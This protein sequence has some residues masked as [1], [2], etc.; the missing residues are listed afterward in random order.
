MK[1]QKN[2]FQLAHDI[3]HER[4]RAR[5][6]KMTNKSFKGFSVFIH[7]EDGSFFM[8]EDALLWEALIEVG[9]K[10][11]G[12]NV[13]FPRHIEP[14]IFYPSDLKACH[15]YGD[16]EEKTWEKTKIYRPKNVRKSAKDYL[17]REGIKLT[18]E[19]FTYEGILIEIGWH[20]KMYLT[21]KKVDMTDDTIYVFTE[22]HGYYAFK[23]KDMQLSVKFNF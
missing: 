2:D 17:K 10:N 23:K 11:Y 22:H 3:L 8:F 16:A 18:C 4:I 13:V 14:Q 5:K 19:D 15:I 6:K 9:D 1:K 21:H 7:H 20:T 12:F